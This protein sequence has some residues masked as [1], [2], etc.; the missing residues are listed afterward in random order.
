MFGGG[1]SEERAPLNRSGS[2]PK[3]M[4]LAPRSNSISQVGRCA[5]P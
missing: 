4:Y 2:Q 5:L 1:S 3:P